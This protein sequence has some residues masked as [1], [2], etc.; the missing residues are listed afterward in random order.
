[1]ASY[2]EQVLGADEHVVATAKLTG[3]I[4]LFPA[5][6]TVATIR[7]LCGRPAIRQAPCRPYFRLR[8]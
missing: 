6:L 1:M 7:L 5:I 8:S 2:I 3:W 4:Y